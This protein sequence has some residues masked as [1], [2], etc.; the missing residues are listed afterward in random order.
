M[1]FTPQLT[2]T[3]VQNIPPGHLFLAQNDEGVEVIYLMLVQDS[4]NPSQ[5]MAVQMVPRSTG[6]W[7][8]AN[9]PS[10]RIASDVNDWYVLTYEPDV[11]NFQ[12]VDP[13]T[14]TPPNPTT[15]PG[16]MISGQLALVGDK[17]CLVV[18]GVNPAIGYG[19]VDLKT[20]AFVDLSQP[21]PSLMT[22]IQKWSLRMKS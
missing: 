9:L 6:T 18:L 1:N 19:M 5:Y 4:L 12:Y 16:H 15:S 22:V 7:W 20:G 13:S 14:L 11:D 10:D 8:T 21:T 3:F 17:T 2:Q